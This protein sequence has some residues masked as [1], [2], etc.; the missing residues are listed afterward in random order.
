MKMFAVREKTP[1]F[2]FNFITGEYG[3]SYATKNHNVFTDTITDPIAYRNGRYVT[4]DNLATA[5]S[6]TCWLNNL[7]ESGYYVFRD[8]TNLDSGWL[9]IVSANNVEIN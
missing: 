6:Y 1:G 2:V 5:H 8:E 4:T 7:A 9:L 3:D